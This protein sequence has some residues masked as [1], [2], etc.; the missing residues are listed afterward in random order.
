[1]SIVST[2]KDVGG[3]LSMVK[4]LE[5]SIN[6]MVPVSNIVNALNVFGSSFKLIVPFAHVVRDQSNILKF[7]SKSVYEVLHLIKTG[8]IDD[9]IRHIY[10]VQ[11]VPKPMSR[12]LYLEIS[13]LPIYDLNEHQKSAL[14]LK[15]K[16][17]DLDAKNVKIS[18]VEKNSSLRR[19][20]NYMSSKKFVS[21][22]GIKVAIGVGAIAAYFA[23]KNHQKKTTGCLRYSKVNGQFNVCKVAECS[24]ENGE[25]MIDKYAYHCGPNVPIPKEMRQ[26][27][28]CKNVTGIGCINCPIEKELENETNIDDD[29]EDESVFYKCNV[30]NFFDAAADI[31]NTSV[32]STIRAV[33]NFGSEIG[34][35]INIVIIVAKFMIIAIPV[36]F[37]TFWTYSKY[38]RAKLL[39]GKAI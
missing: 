10:N 15:N 30:P 11:N 32:D 8:E 13:H 38:N 31:L 12:K 18:D 26:P 2:F 21:F 20:L 1:M 37:M 24:C 28:N 25:M 5:N 6:S 16:F 33:V 14:Q 3:T 7:G 19:M 27:D 29:D 39:T 35:F 36:I 17:T 22:T 9:A 23:I 34:S 4:I